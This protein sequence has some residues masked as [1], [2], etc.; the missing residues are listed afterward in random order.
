VKL[1][2]DE[3]CDALLVDALRSTGHDVLYVK[4]ALVGAEDVVVLQLSVA[5]QRVLLTEDKD[6][7]ELVVRLRLPA[8]GIILLRLPGHES[9]VKTVRLL[10]VLNNYEHRLPGAFTVVDAVKI[11]FRPL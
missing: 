1:L 9:N 10:E 4:D 6:F 11:R 3:C 2:A 7:G 5:E 8:H